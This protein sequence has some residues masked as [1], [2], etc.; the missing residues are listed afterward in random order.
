[1]PG[2]GTPPPH[3]LE[4]SIHAGDRLNKNNTAYI[5]SYVDEYIYIYSCL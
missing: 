4:N 3:D 5:E 1:M 2:A